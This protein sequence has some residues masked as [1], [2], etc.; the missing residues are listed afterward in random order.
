MVERL[1]SATQAVY[2]RDRSTVLKVFATGVGIGVLLMQLAGC[3][4]GSDTGATRVEATEYAYEMPDRVE[5]GL[6][7]MEFVNT[8]D[9]V[10]EWA[11]GRLKKGHSEAELRQ[12]L[13]AGNLQ[14]LASIE[15]IG[16]V[17]AV[18]PGVS[19]TLARQLQPGRY[20]FYS[21]MPAPNGYADFQLGMIRAFDVEGASDAEP[22]D[23]DGTIT[24]REDGFDVPTLGPGTHTLR[25]QNAA[26]DP[27]EFK[28]LSL[29]PAQRPADLER[30]FGDRL[31][32]AAPADLL[33]IVDALPPGGEA[34]ATIT[35]EA[36]RS[37]NLFDGPHKVAARFRVG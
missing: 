23:V 19:L 34:Y 5:E 12:Q 1:E 36:G 35:F 33:G 6:V 9:Q 30:W 7:T 16:S 13:L 18:T 29:K 20:V 2:G 22:P 10:H 31:R 8:G 37:Y 26:K 4:G 14:H 21:T 15:D 17:P 3:G 28:L 25:L 32:G 27:R 11:L 24:A